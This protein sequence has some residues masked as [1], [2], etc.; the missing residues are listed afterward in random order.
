MGGISVREFVLG[1][2]MGLLIS[3]AI[4]YYATPE[5]KHLEELESVLLVIDGF[6]NQKQS[7]LYYEY[8]KLCHTYVQYNGIG[9]EK[10]QDCYT[11]EELITLGEYYSD[12]GG[13]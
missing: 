3:I 10:K 1:T 2:V 11:L 12:L 7:E 13:N 6:E 9:Y 5:P 4:T 8:D